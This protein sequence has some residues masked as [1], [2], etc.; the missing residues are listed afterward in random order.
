MLRQKNTPPEDVAQISRLY[1]SF[2]CRQ[3]MC[4]TQYC[5]IYEDGIVSDTFLIRHSG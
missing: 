1:M 4:F 2:L 3:K 5:K